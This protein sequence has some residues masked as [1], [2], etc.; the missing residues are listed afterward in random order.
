MMN[1]AAF[2]GTPVGLEITLVTLV[3][4]DISTFKAYIL[5]FH[6]LQALLL[7]SNQS[8]N[9][10]LSAC[11]LYN[12][13]KINKF[14]KIIDGIKGKCC[15]IGSWNCRRNLLNYNNEATHK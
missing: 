7:F 11:I 13:M 6:S 3:N 5:G 2:K 4:T 9:H 12:Q 15:N 10:A 14:F 1:W 8:E